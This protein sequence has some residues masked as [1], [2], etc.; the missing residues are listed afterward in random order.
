MRVKGLQESYKKN[1]NDIIEN[2]KKETIT[3][4]RK[5]FQIDSVNKGVGKWVTDNNGN[6][7]FNW[8]S[9][10]EIVME[11]TCTESNK[12]IKGNMVKRDMPFTESDYKIAKEV[13]IDIE[14]ELVKRVSLGIESSFWGNEDIMLKEKVKIEVS[15]AI[16]GMFDGF[17]SLNRTDKK[18]NIRSK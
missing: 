18:Y 8:K 6:V 12:L 9:I 17:E 13:G 5:S 7:I 15:K 3:E 2:T 11:Y 16:H 4:C 1:A 10:P 14:G